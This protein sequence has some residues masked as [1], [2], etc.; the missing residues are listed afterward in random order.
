MVCEV[1]G[2]T[3]QNYYKRK[4]TEDREEAIKK[5]L[6]KIVCDVRKKLP[7]VGT[8]KLLKLI[9]PELLSIGIKCGRDKLFNYLREMNLLIKPKKRY[10]KTTFSKHWMRKYK[11]KSK[12]LLID[13]PEMV[14]VS[15]ITYLNSDEG[16]CYLTL[17]T[18][19]YSRKIV[20]YNVSDN[21]MAENAVK[22]LEMAVNG[23]KYPNQRLI[24]HSDRGLQYCSREYVETALRANITMSMTETSSPYDNALAERMNRTFKEEFYL[25]NT[26]KTKSQVFEVARDA[27]ERYNSYRPHLSLDFYTPNDVHKNSQLLGA[28]GDYLFY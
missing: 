22:A 18:D 25:Y 27:I 24:H 11:N 7:R 9:K 6:F 23:R 2:Y 15:D 4:I 21:L 28:T 20:G 19:A 3:R 26:F 1:L 12:G 14:W 17:I 8:R 10:V 16:N 5:D 13:R